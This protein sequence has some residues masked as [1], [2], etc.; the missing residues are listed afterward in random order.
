MAWIVETAPASEILSLEDFPGFPKQR[1]VL[2]ALEPFLIH[3]DGL[4]ATVFFNT[5]GISEFGRSADVDGIRGHA[6][7]PTAASLDALGSS[8]LARI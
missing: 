6:P 4:L 8:R 3:R 2:S 1:F 7:A 5:E